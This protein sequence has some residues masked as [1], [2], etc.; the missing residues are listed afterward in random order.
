[1]RAFKHVF[2]RLASAALIFALVAVM[3]VFLLS[4]RTLTRHYSIVVAP[5]PVPTSSESIERGGHIAAIRG[6]LACHGNDLGGGLVMDNAAMGRVYGPNLTKGSGGVGGLMTDEDWV[7]AVREGIGADG[8]PLFIMPSKDFVAMS[9]EDLGALLAY[10]RSAAPVARDVPAIVVGPVSRVLLALGK[11]RLSAEVIDHARAPAAIHIGIEV[12]PEY[13]RYLASTCTGCHNPSFSGGKIAE[14]PPN[15]PAA[16]NLTLGPGS[17][18]VG[19]S[20]GDFIRVIRTAVAPDGRVVNPVMP[21][22]FAQM[23]DVELKAL[24]SYLRTLP[25]APTGHSVAAGI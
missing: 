12:S 17:A 8:H 11:T 19:W 24:W 13:G 7:R 15:W 9:D 3:V 22:T 10:I 23:N 21:R 1:M 25:P 2:V 6:C 4:H 16:A 14:G 5:V 18:V 20:E